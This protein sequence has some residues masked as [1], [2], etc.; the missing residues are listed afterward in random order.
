MSLGFGN[1]AR[2][3]HL[4]PSGGLCDYEIQLMAPPGVQFI[5][6]RVPFKKTD[7]NQH[8]V[9][10]AHL[11]NHAGLLVD[12]G[13][14]L[15]AVNCTAVTMLAGSDN[16]RRRLFSATA[17]P[18]V[19]TIDAVVAAL[20]QMKM[21]RIGLLAPYLDEVI[22]AEI[23]YFA[24]QGIEVISHHATPCHS[25]IEQGQYPSSHW[26]EAAKH[27]VGKPIDGLLI[28]CAG[29]QVADQLAAMEQLLQRPVVSSNQ[30]LLWYCL[31]QLQLNLPVYG[32]GSLLAVHP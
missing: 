15:I 5:T 23:A 7:I 12:A 19:T 17:K 22:Q 10:C 6:T 32:Y 27:F 29:I 3:G 24:Q 25:P 20:K 21:Q 31:K 28:S 11:E 9:F 4:Y 2:I 16:L 13:V 30:A 8:H 14:D 1:L 26:F 18:T